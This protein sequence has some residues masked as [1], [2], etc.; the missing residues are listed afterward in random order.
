M[1]KTFII[2]L[3]IPL[4]MINTGCIF[5]NEENNIEIK[6]SIEITNSME[7]S[8]NILLPSIELGEK[9]SDNISVENINTINIEDY[10]ITNGESDLTYEMINGVRFLNISSSSRALNIL[11]K[12][13]YNTNKY[14]NVYSNRPFISSYNY[15]GSYE[16]DYFN[17]YFMNFINL[18]I[19]IKYQLDQDVEGYWEKAHSN[20]IIKEKGLHKIE[21]L[22]TGTSA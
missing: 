19:T 11:L 4:M 18:N 22:R 13:V 16:N 6:Y 17:I 5:N 21:I 10:Q 14:F 9:T 8:F 1:N 15:N 7:E 20:F 12:K 3:L 2:I